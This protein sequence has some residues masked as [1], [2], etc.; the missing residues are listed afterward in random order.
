MIY[1]G[2]IFRMPEPPSGGEAEQGAEGEG[3]CEPTPPPPPQGED[4]QDGSN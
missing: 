2:I 4:G 3:C 1:E